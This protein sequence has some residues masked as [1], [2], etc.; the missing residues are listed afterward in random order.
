M[1]KAGD[2]HPPRTRGRDDG[3]VN[4]LC[5]G[6]I[7]PCDRRDSDEP[8]RSAFCFCVTMEHLTDT[9]RATACV[10]ILIALIGLAPWVILKIDG[11]LTGIDGW[12]TGIEGEERMTA[13]A[14][15]SY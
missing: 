5:A 12:L 7:K 4:P 9:E 3:L 8:C 14:D 2:S 13:V 11:W 1:L 6:L 15:P 10:A